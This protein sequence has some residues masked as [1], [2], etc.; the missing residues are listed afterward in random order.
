M[1]FHFSLLK[2]TKI[3]YLIEMDSLFIVGKPLF[4]VSLQFTPDSEVLDHF[5]VPEVNFYLYFVLLLQTHF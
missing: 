3:L 4:P 1:A 2:N 5:N